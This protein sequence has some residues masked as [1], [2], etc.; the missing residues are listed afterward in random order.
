MS[1][2]E[3]CKLIKTFKTAADATRLGK[4]GID[5]KKLLEMSYD[6][7]S[8]LSSKAFAI[9][10]DNFLLA[11]EVSKLKETD[12]NMNPVADSPILLES[13]YYE[14]DIIPGYLNES[15]FNAF[16]ENYNA[17]KA[18]S[19][20]WIRAAEKSEFTKRC[21]MSKDDITAIVSYFVYDIN[22]TI[23]ML[24]KALAYRTKTS[25][26]PFKTYLLYLLKAIR[27]IKPVKETVLYKATKMEPGAI[28]A[29]KEKRILTWPFFVSASSSLFLDDHKKG[30]VLF[31]IRGNFHGYDVSKFIPRPTFNNGRT[32]RIQEST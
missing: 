23:N 32:P 30:N 24:Q 2:Q 19:K 8:T 13:F 25:L 15:M 16:K 21:G 4:E 31:E 27:K 12:T 29:Y 5:G 3:V 26:L 22:N 17:I 28:E 9:E 20:I 6:E 10:M 7:L 18:K 1:P 11:L 14:D